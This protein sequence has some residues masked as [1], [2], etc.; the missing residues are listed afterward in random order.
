MV[1]MAPLSLSLIETSK[2]IVDAYKEEHGNPKYAFQLHTSHNGS[3]A[4]L[5]AKLPGLKGFMMG[6]RE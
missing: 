5:L 1:P 3:Q 2:G 6:E 4:S